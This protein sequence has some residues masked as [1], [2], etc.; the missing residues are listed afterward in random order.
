MKRFLM[1]LALISSS[2]VYSEVDQEQLS[3]K[4]LSA[5]ER[6]FESDFKKIGALAPHF[7]KKL[8]S[9]LIREK[10]NELLIEGVQDIKTIVL[11]LLE[12]LANHEK[13]QENAPKIDAMVKTFGQGQASLM[14]Y[15]RSPE[16]DKYMILMSAMV[17]EDF[18]GDIEDEEG[19]ATNFKASALLPRFNYFQQR[20]NTI[21]FQHAGISYKHDATVLQTM[22]GY[23]TGAFLLSCLDDEQLW[24]TCF[25]SSYFEILRKT[26]T[27]EEKEYL[28]N[29][30]ADTFRIIY[31][32]YLEPEYKRQLTKFKDSFYPAD[33][34][35]EIAQELGLAVKRYEWSD[36]LY[37][38]DDLTPEES[39]LLEKVTQERLTLER[40]KAVGD[41][42]PLVVEF[43]ALQEKMQKEPILL[44]FASDA[45]KQKLLKRI[46]SACEHFF[47]EFIKELKK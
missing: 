7:A 27:Q 41:S 10:G 44:K 40:F 34:R 20:M 33:F 31:I 4:I 28:K 21:L 29:I 25:D 22:R 1:G 2:L 19:M 16:F 30:W 12:A 15:K 45:E 43:F 36:L 39:E 37:I 6:A 23:F 13:M 14:S 8:K 5:A 26:L 17:W 18:R 38:K 9:N 46:E 42:C 3:Q 11:L 35:I 24:N 32:E 47:S